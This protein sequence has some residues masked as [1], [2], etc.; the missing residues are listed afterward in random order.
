[1]AHRRKPRRRSHGT[2]VA[3]RDAERVGK[4]RRGDPHPHPRDRVAGRSACSTARARRAPG[5]EL[6]GGGLLTLHGRVRAEDLRAAMTRVRDLEPRMLEHWLEQPAEGA[7]F[8]A[9][10][11]R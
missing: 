6:I 11:G 2:A 1:M 7:V 4:A 10:M 3:A 5:A 8:L 9:E